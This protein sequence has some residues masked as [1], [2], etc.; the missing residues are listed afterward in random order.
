[1]RHG[2]AVSFGDLNCRI[3]P[4]PTPTLRNRPTSVLTPAVP[5]PKTSEAS[6][7]SSQNCCTPAPI[8]PM[9]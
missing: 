4:C 2:L 9:S 6:C 1:M 5:A 8:P 7:K 3:S